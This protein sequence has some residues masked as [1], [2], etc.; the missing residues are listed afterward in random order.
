MR[1]SDLC[2]GHGVVTLR[3]SLYVA[4]LCVLKTLTTADSASCE[5]IW[6]SENALVAVAP[7]MPWGMPMSYICLNSLRPL[8]I[9]SE[10][11]MGVLPTAQ[12]PSYGRAHSWSRN[13][14]PSASE[15]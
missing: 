7:S 12:V 4:G 13:Q 11:T 5:A 3:R 10:V 2:D 8:M 6:P 15:S 9:G 1:T 14:K